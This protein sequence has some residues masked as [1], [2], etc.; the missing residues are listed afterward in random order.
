M[1]TSAVL[2]TA[3]PELD[4]LRKTVFV[5]SGTRLKDSVVIAFYRVS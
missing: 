5:G 2:E 3:A 1:R 4:W